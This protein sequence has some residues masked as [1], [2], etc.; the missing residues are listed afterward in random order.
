MKNELF[1]GATFSQHD[2]VQNVQQLKRKI[3]SKVSLDECPSNNHLKLKIYHD[4]KI[5]NIKVTVYLLLGLQF[6]S[7]AHSKK[8]VKESKE[9][10]QLW[11][12]IHQIYKRKKS[13]KAQLT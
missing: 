9:A 6:Q 1:R 8:K 2:I 13:I 4:H 7:Y 12:L 3:L 5:A 10:D 11:L